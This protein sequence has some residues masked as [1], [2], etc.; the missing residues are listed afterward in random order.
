MKKKIVIGLAGKISSGKGS[1]ALYLAK[2]QGADLVMFS[3]CMRN[4]LADLYLPVNRLN[5]QKLSLALRQFFGQEVFSKAVAAEIV[6][7]KQSL[8]VID[9]VRRWAD[10]AGFGK[11]FKFFLVYIESDA[12]LRW[13]RAV[14]R[15]QNQGDAAI[16]WPKFLKTDQA[17]TEATIDALKKKA[18]FVI[19]NNTTKA[20]F[21][22][23]LDQVIL[24][25]KKR[26]NNI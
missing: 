19:T 26:L 3:N 22:L 7:A 12:K 8:V 20:E 13:R 18:D 25:V 1:A 23:K 4:M 9:G 16:S 24:T 6:K 17:E 2:K 14:S 11:Q 10:V 5:L 21:L 15:N